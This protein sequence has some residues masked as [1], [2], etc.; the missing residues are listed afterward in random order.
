MGKLN[1][2][3]LGVDKGVTIDNVDSL[4]N[5]DGEEV[6]TGPGASPGNTAA[7]SCDSPVCVFAGLGVS[8]VSWVTSWCL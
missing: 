3:V 2:R 6:A 4:V 5:D 1:D 7:G 8:G